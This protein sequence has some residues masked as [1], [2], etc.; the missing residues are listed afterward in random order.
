MK[1]EVERQKKLT[2]A[3]IIFPGNV[4]TDCQGR[5]CLV[6]SKLNRFGKFTG[7][8]VDSTDPDASYRIPTV[9]TCGTAIDRGPGP[10][11]T[12]FR[13]KITLTYED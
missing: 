6:T 8:L 13:G 11:Y 3:E 9:V 4:V 5:T 1:I 12:Q 2:D 10:V 7:I